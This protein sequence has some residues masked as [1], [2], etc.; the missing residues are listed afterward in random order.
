[1]LSR[2]IALLI[3]LAG[4]TQMATAAT[5]AELRKC[6]ALNDDPTRLAC[7][8]AAMQSAPTTPASERPAAAPQS[9]AA[10][11]QSSAAAPVSPVTATRQP[12][13]TKADMSTATVAPAPVPTAPATP[14]ATQNTEPSP[15]VQTTEDFGLPKE[16][17]W[18]QIKDN[19]MVATVSGVSK[20]PLGSTIVEL[21]N[22]HVW[23]QVDDKRLT[24]RKGDEVNIREG[25]GGSF[26]LAKTSGSRSLKVRRTK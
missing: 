22:G 5:D 10:A 1:M 11:P 15:A 13:A 25:M 21:D 6:Q 14:V 9:A 3:L 7:Y 8:D 16:P 19:Q 4:I 26:Y 2:P 23:Q 20:T 12:P 17:D 18:E 24:L